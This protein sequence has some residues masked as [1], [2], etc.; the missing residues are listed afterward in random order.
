[1]AGSLYAF[2]PIDISFQLC[3]IMQSKNGKNDQF[4]T[5]GS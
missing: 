4:A 1:M 3:K 5:A 2:I